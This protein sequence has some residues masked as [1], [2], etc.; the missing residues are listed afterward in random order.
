M[1][2][3]GI[4]LGGLCLELHAHADDLGAA[5]ELVAHRSDDRVDVV[6]LILA[7]V[8]DGHHRPVGEEEVGPQQ[9]AI[10]VLEVG[11]VDRRPGLEDRLGLIER[12]HLVDEGPV[13]LG[14]LATLLDLV[15]DRLQVG[16]GELELHDP[17]VLQWVGWTGDVVVCERAEDEDDGVGLS[18]VAEELVAESLTLARAGDEATDVDELNGRRDDVAT[19]AHLGQGRRG[20]DRARGPP[21]RSGRWW[22]RRRARR[23]H[24]HR[25]ARCTATTSLRWG[26]RRT[27]SVPLGWPGYG[28]FTL[29]REPEAGR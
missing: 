29:G 23:A 4:E 24:R 18:D 1:R 21:R 26:A 19:L 22:R 3:L 10:A 6:E 16:V 12:R 20:E 17:E 8:D 11:A 28:R 14:R 7:H 2:S 25:R 5:G 9:E 13:A 27:R 15:L